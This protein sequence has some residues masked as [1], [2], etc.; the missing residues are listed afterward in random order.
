MGKF[1]AIG[2][3]GDLF[4]DDPLCREAKRRSWPESIRASLG[5]DLGVVNF[6]GSLACTLSPRKQTL[7]HM[8]PHVVDVLI[9]ADILTV[10]LANNHIGDGGAGSIGATRKFLESA[11]LQCF[12][13]G[14]NLCEARKPT[15]VQWDTQRIALLGYCSSQAYVGGVAATEDTEGTA[16]I[17]LTY[18]A[19]DIRCLRRRGDVDVVVVYL[20]WG[21]EYRRVPTQEERALAHQLRLLGVDLVIGA[22]PH[23]PRSYEQTNHIYYSLGNFVFPEVRC[24]DGTCLRWDRI[25]RTGLC[26]I[27]KIQDGQATF[28]PK[29]FAIDQH[30]LPLVDSNVSPWQ[31]QLAGVGEYVPRAGWKEATMLR[32]D[33]LFWQIRRFALWRWREVA[34]MASRRVRRQAWGQGKSS[35]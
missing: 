28:S 26:V 15:F 31:R 35:R 16:P 25:S 4:M 8:A 33:D 11:G 18:I 13:A 7:L 30:G 32:S 27:G 24:V 6:E 21:K 12:G 3:F 34:V 23:V 1:P 9:K 19:E 20:H 2:F 10:C 5:Y 14:A 22:H 29:V 17:D